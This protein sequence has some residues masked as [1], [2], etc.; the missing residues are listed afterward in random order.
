MIWKQLILITTCIGISPLEDCAHL[1][2]QEGQELHESDKEPESPPI[3]NIRIGPTCGD[4]EILLLS[5]RDA[6]EN[7]NAPFHE[8]LLLTLNLHLNPFSSLPT[9]TPNQFDT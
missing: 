1:G 6:I 3:Y 7:V 9:R 4:S 2:H 5:I 8:L